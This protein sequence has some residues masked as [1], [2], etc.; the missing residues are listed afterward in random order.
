MAVINYQDIIYQTTDVILTNRLAELKST[1]EMRGVIV[2]ASE[3]SDGIYKV[4]SNNITYEVQGTPN[5]YRKDDIVM[6]FV[7]TDDTE[8]KTI[9][10]ECRALDSEPSV[11][12]GPTEQFISSWK[13]D[14]EGQEEQKV[15]NANSEYYNAL[16]IKADFKNQNE[17]FGIN[18]NLTI[19]ENIYVRT[20]DSRD[21]IGDFSTNSPGGLPQDCVLDISALPAGRITTVGWEAYGCEVSNLNIE[22]GFL[23]NSKEN[24]S[25]DIYCTDKDY[26]NFTSPRYIYKVN[27]KSDGKFY[28]AL[29]AYDEEGNLR[30]GFSLESEAEESKLKRTFE[31][32]Y[33]NRTEE[34][35]YIGFGE[36][37][38]QES[39]AATL[40][41]NFIPTPN[42]KGYSYSNEETV[43]EL[44]SVVYSD[45][46][47]SKRVAI[48]PAIKTANKKLNEILLEYDFS[49]IINTPAEYRFEVLGRLSNAKDHSMKVYFTNGNNEEIVIFEPSSDNK[50]FAK[51]ANDLSI[52]TKFEI[53]QNQDKIELFIPDITD[54]SLVLDE[55]LKLIFKITNNE[56][57]NNS[58]SLTIQ[59]I[60][61]GVAN[62]EYKIQWQSN[63]YNGTWKNL[64][65]NEGA[66]ILHPVFSLD[67][68]FAQNQIRAVLYASSDTPIIS[69][70]VDFTQVGF[71]GEPLTQPANIELQIEHSSNSQSDYPLYDDYMNLINPSDFAID[72]TLIIN[73]K[74]L[75]GYVVDLPQ[76]LR[77]SQIYWGIPSS[78]TMLEI[79]SLE[80]K[81]NNLNPP[82][83]KQDYTYYLDN[84]Y[85][86]PE[87]ET[88]FAT[89]SSFNYR[90]KSTFQP[91]HQNNTIHCIIVDKNN[92]FYEATIT[93]GF[94]ARGNY[95]TDYTLVIKE[96]NG[97]PALTEANKDDYALEAKLYAPNGDE[98]N[99]DIELT[100]DFDKELAQVYTATA[101]VSWGGSEN[102]AREVTLSRP[103][104]VAWSS[105]A[106]WK[107]QGPVHIVYNNTGMEASYW[108][109]EIK[110]LNTTSVYTISLV[111]KTNN[112]EYTPIEEFN[113]S[114]SEYEKLQYR[115]VTEDGKVTLKVP[116]IYT[117]VDNLY[118]KFSS[119][120]SN[121]ETILWLQPLII[122]QMSH[123][124]EILNNWDGN[125]TIDEEG[126][127]IMA[128]AFAAG[129]M[130]KDNSFTGVIAGE[131]E[132]FN[133][134]THLSS[135]VGIFGHNK[136]AETFA[137]RSDGTFDLKG[138]HKDNTTAISLDEEGKLSIKQTSTGED[139]W[140][141]VEST[142][143][144]YSREMGRV[145]HKWR[146]DDLEFQIDYVRASKSQLEKITEPTNIYCFSTYGYYKISE[147]AVYYKWVPTI[148]YEIED[149]EGTII[150][151]HWQKIKYEP[152]PDTEDIIYYESLNDLLEEDDPLDY[153]KLE[154]KIWGLDT[155]TGKLYQWSD[156]SW[157]WNKDLES[158]D[159]YYESKIVQTANSIKLK[160]S[161]DEDEKASLQIYIDDKGSDDEGKIDLTGLVTF[162]NGTAVT[163]IDGG[164]IKTGII[165]D[166]KNKFKI[167]LDNGLIIAD[168][169]TITGG[170]SD[171]NLAIGSSRGDPSYA[172]HLGTG[173]DIDNPNFIQPY[174]AG[175]NIYHFYLNSNWMSL[176]WNIGEDFNYVTIS[177][178]VQFSSALD[179]ENVFLCID[180][181][182]AD[183]E[184]N[185]VYCRDSVFKDENGEWKALEVNSDYIDFTYTLNKNEIIKSWNEK[186]FSGPYI[187]ICLD[188]KGTHDSAVSVR[189]NIYI[190]DLYIRKGSVSG[191]GYAEPPQDS[192]LYSGYKN[193]FKGVEDIINSG[194]WNFSDYIIEKYPLNNDTPYIRL[195]GEIPETG[196][197]HIKQD[198]KIMEKDYY[199]ISCDFRVRGD[200]T[201]YV[202][203]KIEQNGTDIATL[204]N[205]GFRRGGWQTLSLT[206]WQKLE[207]DDV[208]TIYFILDDLKDYEFNTN[209]LQ[210]IE[211]RNPILVKGRIAPSSGGRKIMSQQNSLAALTGGYTDEGLYIQNG[212]LYINASHINAGILSVKNKDKST[213]FE[214][215]V[216]TGAVQIAG[217]E[218]TDKRIT[219][220]HNGVLFYLSSAKDTSNYWITSK[221]GD[222]RYFAITKEGK[223]TAK[224]ADITGTITA[225]SL[226]VENA[227]IKGTLSA[228]V[229][230]GGS[231]NGAASIGGWNI[232][233]HSLT[234]GTW[235]TTTYMGIFT[236]YPSSSPTYVNGMDSSNWRLVVGNKFGITKEGYVVTNSWHFCSDGI[237]AGVY[238]DDPGV[239][240][241]CFEPSYLSLS[242]DPAQSVDWSSVIKAAYAHRKDAWPW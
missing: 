204:R 72:R 69:N 166:Q 233:N 177:G 93:F 116:A 234:A 103:Y 162:K 63:Q 42:C 224:E 182:Q 202:G 113:G 175:K 184:S 143:E 123:D 186:S 122:R 53:K 157:T 60:F 223:L 101:T 32:V 197:P 11:Y 1:T 111:K 102:D 196:K 163:Q 159:T 203:M 36:E 215:N 23:A 190:K 169:L 194:N 104:A 151:T 161:K 241:V 35:V 22:L 61:A 88:V 48:S 30:E 74:G 27:D 148:T 33:Y 158:N 172:V 19:G 207:K 189:G 242:G 188:A 55:K 141:F 179:A 76:F 128:A 115:L 25:L 16:Y 238:P 136:G 118:I 120:D 135:E 24:G 52:I 87:E 126:N 160:V 167:D 14:P 18:I 98:A 5:A 235:A 50:L 40:R 38:Y 68:R 58:L 70:T 217:W 226:N 37:G 195:V 168:Q 4:K 106:D 10:C 153:T 66:D 90:I 219:S 192:N 139:M 124:Y 180:S 89:M 109:E 57:I 3:A 231:L 12:V 132:K 212:H 218:I 145:E 165:Q 77:G 117:P 198:Y 144:R 191:T 147:E 13:W 185:S 170:Q 65:F 183:T 85:R 236:S 201:H 110:L 129:R 137:L 84:R 187:G 164:I 8:V 174:G 20:F 80:D 21:M 227:T 81:D 133:E 222:K 62:T 17:N 237:L 41:E 210:Q 240:H 78:S 71:N 119:S 6:V 112:N 239:R 92:Y 94:S 28:N 220:T 100:P 2:D 221:D 176:L 225:T 209:N 142:A 156:G 232:G 140:N 59:K 134:G 114:S 39:A 99:V 214:A 29:Q 56:G 86:N 44:D 152:T 131:K 193:L 107:Y 95:G 228:D 178:K 75:S 45:Y 125:L 73:P 155:E 96:K 216:N 127:R 146:T 205:Q 9:I 82:M 43:E 83:A 211:I 199:T 208:I 79:G 34:G 154:N 230:K 15:N 181:W 130:E 213:V 47:T 67:P 108:T 171:T 31:L 200:N 51:E 105:Y 64:V 173:I 49:S 121:G 7:P 26:S 46:G 150:S 229:I 97:F 138:Y 54:T 206:T 149:S 91:Q